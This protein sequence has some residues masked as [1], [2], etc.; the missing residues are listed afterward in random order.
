MWAVIGIYAVAIFVHVVKISEV[1]DAFEQLI[2]ATCC[3][4]QENLS[5][6]FAAQVNGGR[7][8]VDGSP[9]NS[10]FSA[11]YIALGMA[12][13]TINHLSWPPPLSLACSVPAGLHDVLGK[14]NV[15]ERQPGH[16][17]GRR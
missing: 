5:D 2:Q 17:P 1:T 15:P 9:T 13:S 3:L 8:R 12:S 4:G 6:K 16:R 11:E 14:V 7:N 10:A